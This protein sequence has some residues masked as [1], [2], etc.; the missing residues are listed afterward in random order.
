MRGGD[1]DVIDR[2]TAAEQAGNAFIACDI[3]R[4]RDGIQPGRYLIET[5]DVAGSDNHVGAFPLGEFGGRKTD[6]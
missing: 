3:G 4:D 6:A 2:A 5:V 1:H